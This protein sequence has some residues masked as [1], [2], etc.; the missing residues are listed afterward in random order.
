MAIT[1]VS[2][3]FANQT[4]GPQL[5]RE[6]LARILSSTPF[7]EADRL[8][9]FLSFVVEESLSGQG[10]R[11][12]ESVIGVEVFGRPAGYDPKSDPIVRVQARRLRTKLGE[13]Y[14]ASPLAAGLQITLPK[15]GYAPD[16]IPA[17]PPAPAPP[18]A[19]VSSPRHRF[20]LALVLAPLAL[21]AAGVF[22]WAKFGGHADLQSPRV[23][24]AYAGYQ[25]ATTANIFSPASARPP[26]RPAR[27]LTSS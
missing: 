23:F 21:I 25:T 14:D 18:L 2:L 13:Y 12:K 27:L 11:L 17:E 19:A 1:P 6:E 22:V 9:R 26:M 3:P 8:Q 10:T 16:F 24:T 4:I 20:R 7:V 5:I 15:G